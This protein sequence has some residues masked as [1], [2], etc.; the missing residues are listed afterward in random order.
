MK[1]EKADIDKI[2]EWLKFNPSLDK[3][4]SLLNDRNPSTGMWFWGGDTF[5]AFKMRR[6]KGLL[7]YGK[8]KP[9]LRAH[10]A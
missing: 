1:E 7:L 8:G 2:H 5:T 9:M 4:D 6:I 10:A 3:L